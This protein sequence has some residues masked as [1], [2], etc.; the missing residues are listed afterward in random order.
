MLGRSFT[1]REV[2]HPMASTHFMTRLHGP[3]AARVPRWAVVSAYL[4]H[5]AVLPSCIWRIA[6][7]T[8]GID[9]VE[10]ADK[11]GAHH[12]WQLVP[13]DWT[14]LYVIVLSI[15]S[16]GLAFLSFGLV[17]RWG[18]VFPRWIPRL[19]G[20]RVPV[21]GAVIPAAIGSTVL[22]IVPYFLFMHYALDSTIDGT[23][24]SDTNLV[25]HGWQNV[26]FAI[27][28]VP[29][30]A[31][32]PLLGALTVHYYRRRRNTIGSASKS[33]KA[34]RARAAP[35]WPPSTRPRNAET[36]SKSSRSGA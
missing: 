19:R 14:W 34:S 11:P 5:L 9:V 12:G 2:E 20:R 29:L 18:E 10:R 28:Y 4:I 17:C 21:H 6:G 26:A 31:W 32:G 16:E 35:R 13:D 7:M 3:T 27:A 36:T 8:L 22:M 25:M 24:T 23:K 33:D 1:H 15:V 30:G